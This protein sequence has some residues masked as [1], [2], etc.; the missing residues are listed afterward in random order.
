MHYAIHKLHWTPSGIIG[1]L[2]SSQEMRAFYFASLGL[3]IKHDQKEASALDRKAAGA[4][5]GR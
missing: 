2:E 1:W 4:K 5:R 3:K